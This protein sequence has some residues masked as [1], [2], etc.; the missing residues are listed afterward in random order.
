MCNPEDL[1]LT[2]TVNINTKIK[3]NIYMPVNAHIKY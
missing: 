3:E 1:I 2:L